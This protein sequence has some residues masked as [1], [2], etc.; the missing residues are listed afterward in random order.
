MYIVWGHIDHFPT[1]PQIQHCWLQYISQHTP[2]IS[3]EYPIVP[4]LYP[5]KPI[6]KSTRA[7]FSLILNK[8]LIP[9][10]SWINPH[11]L[12]LT[13]PHLTR[14]DEI[15]RLPKMVVPPHHPSHET[16]WQFFTWWLG[17]PPFFKKPPSV[18]SI[19]IGFVIGFSN[20]NHQM[21]SQNRATS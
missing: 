19:S 7:L 17:V 2:F 6:P 5:F 9:I 18:S 3:H 4:P 1:H 15:W 13:H 20:I 10:A 8:C 12:V 14:F 11:E 16:I 21:V